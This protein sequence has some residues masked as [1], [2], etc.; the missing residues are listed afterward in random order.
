MGLEALHTTTIMSC[1]S[2]RKCL[3]HQGHKG[4]PEVTLG[5]C[6]M[7]N[8]VIQ[9]DLI[10]GMGPRALKMPSIHTNS[11]WLRWGAKGSSPRPDSK[12]LRR[13][14]VGHGS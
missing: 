1:T 2:L 12:M 14:S 8:E 9:V 11:T 13:F 6:V 4:D 5:T 10:V 7:F 3:Q